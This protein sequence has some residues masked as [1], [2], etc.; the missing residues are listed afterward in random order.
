M[1]KSRM[2]AVVGPGCRGNKPEKKVA[3]DGVSLDAAWSKTAG[4]PYA[5]MHNGE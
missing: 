3:A 5:I 4:A 1:P 2:E